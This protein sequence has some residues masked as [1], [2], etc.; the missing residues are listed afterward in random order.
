MNINVV[1][2]KF[3]YLPLFEKRDQYSTSIELVEKAIQKRFSQTTTSSLITE[4]GQSARIYTDNPSLLRCKKLEFLIQELF[5]RIRSEGE[6][7]KDAI[8][9]LLPFEQNVS[10]LKAY[11]SE[12]SSK[13]LLLD[14]EK[15][16]QP[17]LKE[18]KKIDKLKKLQEKLSAETDLSE[19]CISHGIVEF[20]ANLIS[21]KP[22]AFI[23]SD[24]LSTQESNSHIDN[25]LSLSKMLGA[26]VGSWKNLIR[27]DSSLLEI[28]LFDFIESKKGSLEELEPSALE[29][30]GISS[31]KELKIRALEVY[32]K[33]RITPDERDSILNEI[34]SS[35]S[36]RERESVLSENSEN[37]EFTPTLEDLKRDIHLLATARLS[38]GLGDFHYHSKNTRSIFRWPAFF[39]NPFEKN[40][41]N[42]CQNLLKDLPN[43][44]TF[45]FI[46]EE[47]DASVAHEASNA[48]FKKVHKAAL[49]LLE[50]TTP[51]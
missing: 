2:S 27:S 41:K 39:R 34:T 29:K 33:K 1:F 6:Q 42:L 3:N 10:S 48:H 28:S 35:L 12:T 43:L 5:T 37:A 17:L 8:N 26:K 32:L 15:H 9:I 31:L 23:E 30:N 16:N 46:K 21:K 45:D 11:F 38:T 4:F 20:A 47:V 36:K 50:E 49:R 51:A 13:N 14:L 22:N 40:Y 18:L 7:R 19:L 24:A 44:G 25:F